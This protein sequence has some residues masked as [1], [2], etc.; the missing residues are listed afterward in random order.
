[1]KTRV[2]L[3]I[4]SITSAGLIQQALPQTCENLCDTHNNTAYGN[5]ALGSLTTG[6]GNT[7]IG[8]LALLFADA[9]SNNTA[10]G[11]SALYYNKADNNIAIGVD[12][13]VAN[14]TGTQNTA[15]GISSLISNVNGNANTAI[16]F[17]ALA[18][19]NGDASTAVGFQALMNNTTGFGNNAEGYNALFKNNSGDGNTATGFF[20][21]SSN[22]TGSSNTAFGYSALSNTVSA[23]GNTALGH[24][25]LV[26]ATGN[27]N[28]AVGELAGQNLTGGNNN[29]DVG[30]KGK[31]GESATIRLGTQGTQNATFIAGISGVAVTGRQVLIT[32]N[33]K[34]G[35]Q[36]SSARFKEQI[37]PMDKT[38]EAILKLKPVTFR[39]KENI[40]PDKV[41][42]F[43]LIAEDVEKVAP[44]LVV[45]DEEGNVSTVRYEAVNVMLLNEVLKEHRRVQLLEAEQKEAQAKVTRQEEQV[46]ALTADLKNVRDQLISAQPILTAGK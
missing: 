7:A 17:N 20:A 40:D 43:G 8:S 4:L 16:G 23:S 42:Q 15:I 46:N 13:M 25:A 33:G 24:F 21:L 34:L 32:S 31:A 28:I 37:R 30:N 14:R 10:I 3:V 1:M 27:S 38:S 39:Y 19:Y 22:T 11:F 5:D 29:I 35:V 45:R 6:H 41:P 36:A 2:T 44:E 18:N 9:N 26:N 12:A